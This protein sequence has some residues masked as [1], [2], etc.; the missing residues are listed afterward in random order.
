MKTKLIAALAALIV[1]LV[2]VLV[3]VWALVLR[4]GGDDEARVSDPTPVDP[5]G[6]SSETSGPNG[7]AT[8]PNDPAFKAALSEPVEDSVYPNV[9]DPSV[10]ALHYGLDLEWDPESS[11]LTG[12]AEIAFRATSTQEQFQLDLGKPLEVEAVTVD[13]NEVDYVHSGKDLVVKSPVQMD[14]RYVAVIDYAGTPEP[15]KAPTTRSDF[16]DIGFTITED[17]E[18]WTMQEPYGAFTWYPVNDQP[19]DKALYDFTITTPEPLIGVANGT[20][21]DRTDDDDQTV[22]TWHLDSPASSYLTTLAIGEYERTTEKSRSGVPLSYWTPVDDPQAKQ[23]LRYTPVAMDWLEDKLGPYPYDSLGSVVVPSESAMETQTMIT[24]GNT[25][26]A[27]S[28]E[29]VVHEMAHHWYGDTVSPSDW[30]DVWMNEGMAMYLQGAFA[31][32]QSHR[33]VD[34]VMEEYAVVERSSRRIDGPPADYDPRTFGQ[35]N[36]YYGPALM[37][38]ELR[39]KIGDDRFWA[40]VKAWPSV[41]KDGNTDRKEYLA[42]IE[43]QTGEELTAFFDDWLLGKKTPK[44]R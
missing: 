33:T 16:T 29:T 12:N 18:V 23:A 36:I 4:S 30:S 37:W 19:A 20:L 35:N 38:H 28:P 26:Y 41:H 7:P 31:A 17:G 25:E 6:T 9:G 40:M 39:K 24:Y 13:G 42:W 10:D 2:V 43:K 11:I 34:K 22:T 8:D 14:R 1:V 21:V 32:Q 44:R 27:L 3:G 15:A 5:D